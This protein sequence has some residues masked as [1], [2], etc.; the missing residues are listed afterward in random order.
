MSVVT[1][2]TFFPAFLKTLGLLFLYIFIGLFIDSV[3]VVKNYEDLQWLANLIM[4]VI[5]GITLF[6]VNPRIRETMIYAVLIGYF[7][8][9]LFSVL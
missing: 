4:V 9:Y 3:Y 6:K 1:T 7:G 5:F 2:K 8:E